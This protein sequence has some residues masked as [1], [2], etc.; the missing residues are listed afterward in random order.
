MRAGAVGPSG[1]VADSVYYQLFQ[2]IC[3][4]KDRDHSVCGIAGIVGKLSPD[5]R[6]LRRMAES[7]R[8]RGPDDEGYVVFDSNRSW[9]FGGKDTPSAAFEIA[10]AYRP[11][12]AV[13]AGCELLVGLAHRRLSIQDISPLGHQ[14]M[15]SED[16]RYWIVFN[17]EIY[18]YIELREELRRLGHR[19]RSDTDTEVILAAYDQWG[20]ECLRRF[21]GMWAF[22]IY[23]RQKRELFLARDRFGVKPLYLWYSPAG[24]L[25]FASEIKQFTV[26]AGWQARVNGQ[27]A[28]DFL[29]HG[30]SDNT[31]E[32]MFQ[33]V[34][35]IRPGCRATVQADAIGN[36]RS[37]N[38]ITVEQWYV[39]RPT[40]FSGSFLDA[41]E[42][43]RSRLVNSVRLRLRADVPVGSCLSGG[44]D[45]S[46]IVG[47]IA[48]L[49]AA[50]RVPAIGEGR[51]KTFSA[52]SLVEAY[53]ERRWV[54]SV[55]RHTGVEAH[56]TYPDVGS[57]FEDARRI[58]WHQDEP[59][60]STS[61]YAQWH[62]FRIA[63]ETGIKVMLDGQ[64]A[65][66]HL[67]GY[68][69]FFGARL[70]FLLRQ[71][72][73]G[74]FAREA[75][76][77]HHKHG[78]RVGSLLKQVSPHL[79]P[80]WASDLGRRLFSLV[81]PA[82]NWLN[83]GKLGAE[84]RNPFDSSGLFDASMT[85]MSLSQLTSSNLQMLLHW[86][87]RNSMAHGIEARVPFLDYRVVEF[88]TSLPDE[89]KLYRGMTKRILREAAQ[90]L[91][92]EDVAGRV[93]KMGFVTAE[94]VWLRELAPD[95]FRSAIAATVDQVAGLFEGARLQH[96]LDKIISGSRGFSFLPWRIISFG[97][98]W[99]AFNVAL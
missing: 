85:A 42:E 28:Y 76:A 91:I 98:W 59:F 57:L 32:T 34:F 67:A 44:L 43:F 62:V 86:E 20:G 60:G 94:E 35:Q 81:H 78:Y 80:A 9:A 24:Y 10:T 95:Q 90:E 53:S 40:R 11:E 74:E 26:L 29:V 6:E 65:D 46:T 2:G 15:C 69:M 36:I 89:F 68:H 54:D 71:F 50:D 22:A 23:D 88:V 61:V 13:D 73:W 37:A 97:D 3:L 83:M 70:G 27:R 92:P 45:S 56:F 19:F 66:E 48:R 21:N 51:Q 38:D 31:D 16:G 5:G 79:L 17:G 4:A 82:P 39:L 8:H 77:I 84:P 55:V 14:P 75:V 58:A 63:A 49:L 64:G 18:G 47:I 41:T 96:E 1:G 52:C 72:Q 99:R 12:S 93:D 30:L 33:G 25:A 87:D 7:V